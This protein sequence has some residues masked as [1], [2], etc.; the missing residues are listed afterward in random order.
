MLKQ[1]LTRVFMS[2]VSFTCCTSIRF[3]RSF[4]H[5]HIGV[6]YTKH[7]NLTKT[8]CR[9]SLVKYRNLSLRLQKLHVSNIVCKT[10]FGISKT[11]INTDKD[12]NSHG[13]DEVVSCKESNEM[14]SK[15]SIEKNVSSL[16][17]TADNNKMIIDENL[18]LTDLNKNL[19]HLDFASRG[20]LYD[21]LGLENDSIGELNEIFSSDDDISETK[22]PSALFKDDAVQTRM[23]LQKNCYSEEELD[24][25]VFLEKI[26][27]ISASVNE[28]KKTSE[29]SASVNEKIKTRKRTV[30]KSSDLCSMT[31]ID[32]IRNDKCIDIN[33]I[34]ERKV[35]LPDV[36]D[37]ADIVNDSPT[38]IKCLEL[39]VNISKVHYKGMIDKF[40]LM[41]FESDIKPYLLL[42]HDTRIPV[43]QWGEIL[44]MCPY[45]FQHDVKS[46]KVR[47][48]YLRSKKLKA[49]VIAEMIKKEPSFLCLPVERIDKKL[50]FIQKEFKLNGNEVRKVISEW[51]RV[52]II[53]QE[54]VL[55]RKFVLKHYLEFTEDQLKLMFVTF[56]LLFNKSLT[57]IQDSHAYLH[58]NMEIPNEL[59]ALYP[60][61]LAGSKMVYETRHRFLMKL[62]CAQYNPTKENY[63]SLQSL[64]ML[65]DEGFAVEVG[66]VSL[67]EFDKFQ[68][69]I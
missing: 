5:T 34:K 68:R 48:D 66:K 46:L 21:T 36:I 65:D 55:E 56:P 4:H 6:V 50:G 35:V 20:A 15:G 57:K 10:E 3:A 11:E 44:S 14:L 62:G 19:N 7:C 13:F 54:T 45:L 60:F 49:V 41:D 9:C 53:P 52:L 61:I 47:I 32:V 64:L 42:F 8:L 27:E 39:G 31:E 24:R 17:I 12:K 30:K 22:W 38:L 1:G 43:E 16:N 37:L 28:S 59:I 29:I 69:L 25:D 58:D 18:E 2:Y 26:S 51:P 33:T 23:E 63:V 40:L 67:E